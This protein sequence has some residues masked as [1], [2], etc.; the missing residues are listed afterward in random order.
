MKAGFVWTSDPPKVKRLREDVLDA[1]RPIKQTIRVAIDRKR[2]AGKSVTAAGRLP[3]QRGIVGGV[4]GGIEEKCDASG[5]ANDGETEIQGT[6]SRRVRAGAD[7]LSRSQEGSPEERGVPRCL[8]LHGAR[9]ALCQPME[10]RHG[11]G[12]RV[13]SDGPLPIVGEA[14]IDHHHVV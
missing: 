7:R 8:R 11:E 5:S 10:R 4:G 6:A 3:A 13:A 2:R 14:G 1:P 12:D 9:L